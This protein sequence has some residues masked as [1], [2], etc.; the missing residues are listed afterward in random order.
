MK[1]VLSLILAL[2]III[3]C[4]AMMQIVSFADDTEVGTEAIK[5]TSTSS[6]SWVK[7]SSGYLTDVLGYSKDYTGDVILKYYVYNAG[8]KK[9]SAEF[10]TQAGVKIYMAEDAETTTEQWASYDS[11][12]VAKCTDLASKA[13]TTVTYTLPVVNGVVTGT[14]GDK[15]GE[16]HTAK[17][18]DFFVRITVATDNSTLIILP[19]GDNDSAENTFNKFNQG[20][21]SR[22]LV[23]A[24]IALTDGI[25][26]FGFEDTAYNGLFSTY[27]GTKELVTSETGKVHSGSYAMK[28]S[29]GTAQYCG[30]K[31]NSSAMYNVVNHKAGLYKVSAWYYFETMPTDG[32]T[33]LGLSS[34]L[35]GGSKYNNTTRSNDKNIEVGIWKQHTF[36]INLTQEFVDNST[37]DLAFSE[38]AGNGSVYYIDDI[39]IERV[40]GLDK[41]TGFTVTYNKETTGAHYYNSPTKLLT[42]DDIVDGKVTKDFV[43]KNNGTENVKIKIEFQVVSGSG[44][45]GKG[46]TTVTVE[47]NQEVKAGCFIA[48][49]EDGNFTIKEKEFNISQAFI[50]IDYD[51]GGATTLPAGTSVTVYCESNI[52]RNLYVSGSGNFSESRIDSFV[53]ELPISSTVSD[54]TLNMDIGSTLDMNWYAT[55]ASTG[56]AENAVVKVKDGSGAVK[57]ELTGSH[58]ENGKYKFAFT[59]VAPQDMAKEYTAELWVKGVKVSARTESVKSYCKQVC[60]LETT[61]ETTKT[62]MSD[63]L[64]YGQAFAD[65]KNTGATIVTEADNWLTGSDFESIKSNLQK[66]KNVSEVLDANNKI[67]SAGLYFYNENKIY[68]RVTAEEGSTVKINGTATTAKN[69]KYYT[70]GI[71]ATEFGKKFTV[72]VEKDG[73]TVHS[74]DY[75]VN[76]YILVKCEGEENIN[77]LGRALAC[78]GNSANEVKGQ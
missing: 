68:F 30:I 36:L 60:N 15:K 72:T 22:E 65:Y 1:K 46:G 37:I 12:T 74:A 69:G 47:P 49:D 50:R 77:K 6:Y 31:L 13:Y 63:M 52:A 2:A 42:T 25:F 26:D 48:V 18:E 27:G 9:A 64:L 24:D 59:D 73:Q 71:K 33:T 19:L 57:A 67:T 29:G 20:N 16:N 78:Y 3:S 40:T 43:V 14:F 58:M 23:K 21:L 66:Q 61:T 35:N 55:F 10:C 39:R 70:D 56:T 45:I 44:W 54:L 17:I 38:G 76:D 51:G 28:Y 32:K 34:R 41:I 7:T 53:T 62:F 11:S 75:S 4:V 8:D 5:V